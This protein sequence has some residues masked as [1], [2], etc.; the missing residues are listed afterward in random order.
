ML[1][2][3][4]SKEITT[5]NSFKLSYKWEMKTLPRRIIQSYPV[6]LDKK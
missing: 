2:T 1:T 6:S 3:Q 4:L 5:G